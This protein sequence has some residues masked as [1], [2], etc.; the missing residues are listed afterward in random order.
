[1]KSGAS[2]VVEWCVQA[3]PS[4]WARGRPT[5]DYAIPIR[6]PA[7]CHRY[8][9]NVTALHTALQDIQPEG[10]YNLL[11]MCGGGQIS[12]EM[13]RHLRRDGERIAFLGI[14]DTWAFYTVSKLVRLHRL[15]CRVWWY[16]V[17]LSQMF[18]NGPASGIRELVEYV[19]GPKHRVAM[20]TLSER[21]TS[22]AVDPL[23]N[24]RLEPSAVVDNT[25]EWL[26]EF[27]SA[28]REPP[29]PPVD[30]K[31]TVFRRQR[32]PYWRIRDRG[33]GWGKHAAA[34]EVVELKCEEHFSILR[35]PHV[36]EMADMLERSIAAA[37]R[38]NV[39][40]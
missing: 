28:D 2:R 13:A 5:A 7:R 26:D 10:P 3:S 38:E 21:T 20:E 4:T 15:R 39:D 40:S 31:V 19:V 18:A 8:E 34:L 12:L 30:C 29:V 32:Q 25:L 9:R 22:N 23:D 17:R 33:L 37:G 1:V 11:G 6:I 24:S 14:L 16:R 27:G 35:E 36:R